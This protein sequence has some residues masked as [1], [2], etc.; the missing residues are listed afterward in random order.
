MIDDKQIIRWA[1]AHARV[2]LSEDGDI[3]LTKLEE[4]T[5]AHFDIPLQDFED[6][7]L[8]FAIFSA[9]DRLK[10]IPE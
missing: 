2:M 1:L 9:L 10:L 7:D 3:C 8:S 4:D 5:I 6:R